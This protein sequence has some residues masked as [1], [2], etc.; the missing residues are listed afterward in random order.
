MRIFGLR[1]GGARQERHEL[2]DTYAEEMARQREARTKER[3][4]VASELFNAMDGLLKRADDLS[5]ARSK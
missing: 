5:I 2:I 3:K 1:L 4:A